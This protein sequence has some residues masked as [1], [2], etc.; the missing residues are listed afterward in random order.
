MFRKLQA[1]LLEFAP[2]Q[3]LKQLSAGA[4]TLAPRLTGSHSPILSIE[5]GNRLPPI[6]S[7]SSVIIPNLNS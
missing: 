1:T 4:R 6:S 7:N 5:K 2:A 3:E